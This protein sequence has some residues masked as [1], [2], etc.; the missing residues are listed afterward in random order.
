MF[1]GSS[2]HIKFD[3][4]RPME[5]FSWTPLRSTR[6]LLIYLVICLMC[7]LNL[8]TMLS[9]RVVANNMVQAMLVPD[10][11]S[12]EVD[13]VPV[14]DMVPLEFLPKPPTL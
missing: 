7:L 6:L 5:D 9:F 10:A 13:L 1:R 4:N 3:Q 2:G 14:L 11:M 8:P 12:T